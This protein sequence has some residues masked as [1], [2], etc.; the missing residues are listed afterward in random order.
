VIKP[1]DVILGDIDGV[2]VVPRD[3]TYE[4]L[5]RAEE[6]RAN[7]IKSFGRVAEV[8]TVQE[9]TDKGGYF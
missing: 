4:V 1:G 6:I 5:V 8:Q 3:I 2:V 7:E 9:V